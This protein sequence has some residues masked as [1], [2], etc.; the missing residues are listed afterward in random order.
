MARHLAEGPYGFHSAIVLVPSTN[1]ALG[2]VLTQGWTTIGGHESG[3]LLRCVRDDLSDAPTMSELAGEDRLIAVRKGS[4]DDLIIRILQGVE[5]YS[6]QTVDYDA[7][8]EVTFDG[9]NCHSLTYGILQ[10]VGLTPPSLG[11]NITR[12]PGYHEPYQVPYYYFQ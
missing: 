4:V 3:G 1:D 2:T 5:N 11:I 9:W 12:T 10:F 6:H 7:V 8:P